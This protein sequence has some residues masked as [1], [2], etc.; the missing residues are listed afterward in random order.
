MRGIFD[1]C[2][3]VAS[4]GERRDGRSPRFVHLTASIFAWQFIVV[5]HAVRKEGYMKTFV[6]TIIGF[7][8]TFLCLFHVGRMSKTVLIRIKV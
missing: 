2:T 4:A 3:M 6:A 1:F 7:L 5:V 8:F